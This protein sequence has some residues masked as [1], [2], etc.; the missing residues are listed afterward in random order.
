MRKDSEVEKLEI[1]GIRIPIK[2]LIND[3]VQI[4]MA[5]WQIHIQYQGKILDNVADYKEN[6]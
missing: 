6:Y 1:L 4:I 5:Y 3:G 2:N